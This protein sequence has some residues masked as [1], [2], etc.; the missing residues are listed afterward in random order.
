MAAGKHMPQT[1]QHNIASNLFALTSGTTSATAVVHGLIWAT[2]LEAA[3]API[4]SHLLINRR[5]LLRESATACSLDVG[6]VPAALQRVV[7]VFVEVL[8]LSS[9]LDRVKRSR[10]SSLFMS[11]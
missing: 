3:V 7:S 4:I 2:S 6:L 1:Q 9:R 11:F 8:L 10:Y 5:E